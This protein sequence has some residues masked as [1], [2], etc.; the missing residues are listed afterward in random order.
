MTRSR[1]IR[2]TSNDS[3]FKMKSLSLYVRVLILFIRFV[4][5]LCTLSMAS[6]S[7]NKNGDHIPEQYSNNG[8]MYI[9][10][11]MVNRLS[12]SDTKP[13]NSTPS[14]WYALFVIIFICSSNRRQLST[15]TPKSHMWLTDSKMILF[16]E[17]SESGFFSPSVNFYTL[18]N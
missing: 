4:K 15:S 7:F 18:K 14:L 3:M 6:I 16:K 12:F 11:A 1:L 17:Y 13:L 2:L 8:L 10:Y 5:Y 9:L